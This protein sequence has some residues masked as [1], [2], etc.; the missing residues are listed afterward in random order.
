MGCLNFRRLIPSL[1]TGFGQTGEVGRGL[2]DLRGAVGEMTSID[3]QHST[4][5]TI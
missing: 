2:V 4:A 5:D 1:F 3:V